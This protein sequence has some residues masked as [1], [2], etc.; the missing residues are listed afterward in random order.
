MLKIT[1]K[2]RERGEKERERTIARVSQ[3]EELEE[4]LS[5]LSAEDRSAVERITREVDSKI[6]EA[7]RESAKELKMIE[8]GRCPE[9]GKKVRRFLFT[10]ICEHCGWSSFLRPQQGRTMVHLRG[11]ATLVCEETFCTPD[12]VLCVT[13]DVVRYR[14]PRDQVVFIEFDWPEEEIGERRTQ[15]ARQE[16]GQCSWC[17]RTLHGGDPEVRTTFAAFGLHQERYLFCSEKCQESFQKQYATRIHRDCY[18][19]DCS[20][21]NECIKRFEDTSYETFLEEEFV[22]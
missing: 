12:E 6:V 19:R 1:K 18:H 3:D 14:V 22:H 15:L 10:T 7:A 2:Q 13:D 11:G 21:C 17:T 8:E 4:H 5:L 9:C 20:K 16:Q